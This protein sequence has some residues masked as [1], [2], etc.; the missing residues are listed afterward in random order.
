VRASLILGYGNPLRSDDGVGYKAGCELESELCPAEVSIVAAHQLLPEHGELA[1]RA[2]RVLFL[3]ASH[4][5][6]PGEI[7]CEA[8]LRD[9]YFQPGTL[10]HDLHPS[11]VLELAS[12]YFHA[13]PEAWLLTLTGAD[14]ELGESFSAAV[15]AAWPGYLDRI[16]AWARG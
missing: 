11:G 12:R 14:F 5:G 7:R 8:I 9:P 10:T 1:S 16:R 3:D 15:A 13:E 2:A 4:E 6:V